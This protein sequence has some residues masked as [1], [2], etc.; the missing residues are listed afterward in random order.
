MCGVEQNHFFKPARI[1]LGQRRA[2]F[3]EI[4]S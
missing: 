3:G 1:I 4:G 2:M